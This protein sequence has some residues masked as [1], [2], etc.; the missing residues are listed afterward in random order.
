MSATRTPRRKA[1]TESEY[2]KIPY[3]SQCC[4]AAIA[5]ITR[6]H[7]EPGIQVLDSIIFQNIPHD[8]RFISA[9]SIDGTKG[10]VYNT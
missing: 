9:S 8:F 6:S 1:E 5:T 7:R 10:S 3:A 4:I 2:L